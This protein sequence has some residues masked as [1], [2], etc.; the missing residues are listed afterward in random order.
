MEE[1]TDDD[2]LDYKPSPTRNDM[3]VNVV[4]LSSTDYTLHEEEEVSQLVLGSQDIVFK[5]LVESED[6]LK[7]LYIHGHLDSTP[8]A[9]ML[10]D[11][12]TAVNVMPC[13]TSRSLGR[14]MPN[15]SR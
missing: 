12:G 11:A 6:H 13:A 7:P 2:F 10:V 8:V 3:E 4:F 15:L 9:R 1:D 14:P 5:K